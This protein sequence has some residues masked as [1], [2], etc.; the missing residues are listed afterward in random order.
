MKTHLKVQQKLDMMGIGAQHQRDPN[1]IAWKQNKEF[2]ALLKRLNKSDDQGGGM[3]E[4]DAQRTA[5]GTAFVC[6]REEQLANESSVVTKKRKHGDEDDIDAIE[7]TKKKKDKKK[8][9]KSSS[10]KAATSTLDSTSESPSLRAP[11]PSASVAKHRPMAHRARIRAAKRITD[12]SAS[13]ISEILGIAPSS[14]ISS[15]T[16]TPASITPST[17]DP[18]PSLSLN[19]LTTSTKSVADYFKEKLLSRSSTSS[20]PMTSSA[21]SGS[22]TPGLGATG[23]GFESSKISPPNDEDDSPR[24]GIGSRAPAIIPLLQVPEATSDGN[25]TDGR[26]VL[27]EKQRRKLEREERKRRNT[28]GN[29]GVSTSSKEQTKED[30]ATTVWKTSKEKK[31]RERKQRAPTDGLSGDDDTIAEIVREGDTPRDSSQKPHK[32]S[33]REHKKKRSEH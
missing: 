16:S 12:K 2:E 9:S 7:N 22:V 15:S 25:D 3:D 31:R 17:S 14:S 4:V 21:P 28:E 19:K 32:K 18:P 13:A 1:G 5:L 8:R 23:L 24:R 11:S 27:A 6:A 26:D 30:D 10:N 29:Q 20:S 33:K